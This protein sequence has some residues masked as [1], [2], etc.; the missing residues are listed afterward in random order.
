[1]YQTNL[2]MSFKW[3]FKIFLNILFQNWHANV[4]ELL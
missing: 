2:P 3:L 4:D 1:M